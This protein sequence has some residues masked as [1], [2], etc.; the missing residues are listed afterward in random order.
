[1]SIPP[2]PCEFG[3]DSSRGASTRSLLKSLTLV[4][5]TEEEEEMEDAEELRMVKG[6]DYAHDDFYDALKEV[7]QEFEQ[8]LEEHFRLFLLCCRSR[9]TN[10]TTLIVILIFFDCL[11]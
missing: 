5:Q 10:R 9:S 2:L 7:P 1:M 3:G 4:S 11:V 8:V 6:T